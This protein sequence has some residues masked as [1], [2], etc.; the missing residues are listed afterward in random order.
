MIINCEFRQN[1]VSFVTFGASRFSRF[2]A[3]C[4]LVFISDLTLFSYSQYE[5]FFV[6]LG[7]MS[8]HEGFCV[9]LGTCA[10]ISRII[11]AWS[12]SDGFTTPR[13]PWRHEWWGG[14]S[15]SRALCLKYLGSCE[16]SSWLAQMHFLLST[17]H[18]WGW[19]SV[20]RGQTQLKIEN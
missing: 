10:S 19:Y 16:N 5:G 12:V 4:L 15:A 8:Q 18:T 7:R 13:W 20:K 6:K 1:S 11:L 3:V 17:S 9:K 14:H 2:A